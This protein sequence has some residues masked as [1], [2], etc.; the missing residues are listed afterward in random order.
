[1]TPGAQE[2]TV[3]I[4]LVEDDDLDAEAV[5]RAFRKQKI[6]NP[7]HKV[8]DGVEALGLLRG[9]NGKPPLQ[10]PYMVLLDLN[11]PRMDGIEF[12]EELRKDPD[13][14]DTIVFMLTTSDAETDKIAAYRKQVAGY[15]VKSKAGEEFVN[16]TRMVDCYW[17]FVEFPPE[18]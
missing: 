4:V 6:A 3:K 10:R 12:L 15:L 2:T 16:L 7:I 9:A 13:L 1:M 11:M 18:R 17:R 5:E 8:T 14:L